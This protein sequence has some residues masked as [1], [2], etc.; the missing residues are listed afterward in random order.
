MAG[1]GTLGQTDPIYEQ[2]M[3]AYPDLMADYEQN[4][5]GKGVTMSEYGQMH[6]EGT[7]QA[8]GRQLGGASSGGG[9]G[10]G[11]GG[12]PDPMVEEMKR[13]EAA[14]LAAETERKDTMNKNNASIN[15]MYDDRSKQF[16]KYGDD[17]YGHNKTQFDDSANDAR[18]QTNF[19][20]ARSG[21]TGGSVNAHTNSELDSMYQK[22]LTNLR[23][24]STD[25]AGSLKAQD[26]QM[27]NNALQMSAS[28]NYSS[29]YQPK[30][31]GS[32][33]NMTSLNSGV[34]N[35][36]GSLLGGIGG[37]SKQKNPWS[38]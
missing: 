30:N 22:G 34:G 23:S 25:A 8:E 33:T 19:A 31:V 6:Y 27:R 35:Q 28:G 20:L 5:A 3:M 37:A 7:G 11:G 1:N 4:W 21:Q 38:Y 14:R 26:N 16:D 9:G 32:S 13:Q 36:F 29:A 10:G 18:Q 15:S 2:Y 17:L 24:G 12:G